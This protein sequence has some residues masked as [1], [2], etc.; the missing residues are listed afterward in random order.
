MT[1]RID[2]VATGLIVTIVL[3]SY[4][5]FFR[6]E[7]LRIHA[8]EEEKAALSQTLE[9]GGGATLAL[10]KMSEEIQRIQTNLDH[11][12]NQLPEEGRIHDFLRTLDRL[13][14]NH[15]VQL[16]AVTPAAKVEANRY[17]KIPVT[18]TAR[19]SFP[20]FYRFLYQLEGIERITK[21]ER[22]QVNRSSKGRV[23]LEA[24]NLCDIQMDLAVYVAGGG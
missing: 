5:F 8:L 2:M 16:Q 12:E 9:A 13:A 24:P 3:L 20:A 21:V 4:F 22:L 19:S 11:F 18:I 14:Q 1:K 7:R 17:A 23:E 10:D 15:G 6:T